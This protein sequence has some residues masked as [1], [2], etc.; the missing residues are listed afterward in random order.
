[1]VTFFRTCSV[2]Q[3]SLQ[4]ESAPLKLVPAVENIG[5]MAMDSSGKAEVPD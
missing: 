4:P 1:M 3:R 5:L 2:V